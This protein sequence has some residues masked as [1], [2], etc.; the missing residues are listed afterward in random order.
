MKETKKE[1][2]Y[3]LQKA[4]AGER[5][6]ALAYNGH[7]KSLKDPKEIAQI[8]IIENDE[9]VHRARISEMLTEFGAKPLILRETLFFVIGWS[10]AIIC[11]FCGRFCST[12]F[13]GI[14][15]NSNVCEYKTAFEYAET[16]GLKDYAKD[17]LEM[18]K[19]EMEHEIV[20]Q[21]MIYQ[22]PFLP[23]FAFFFRWGSNEKFIVAQQNTEI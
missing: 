13:A 14:L 21:K 2:I 16:L 5:A 20:L 22:H 23:F 3:L 9:W 12:Y 1:L 8:Q 7:W 4:H 11:H 19:T 6:A 10:V 18:E 17:F 15:E